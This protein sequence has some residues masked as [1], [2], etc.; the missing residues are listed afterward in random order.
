MG[1]HY[2]TYPLEIKNFLDLS[3][4]SNAMPNDI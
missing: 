4:V 2:T 3:E 1:D